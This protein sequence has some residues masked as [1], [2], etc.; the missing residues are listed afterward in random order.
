MLI[1]P[2]KPLKSATQYLVVVTRQVTSTDGVP[3]E[4]ADLFRVVRSETPVSQQT[5]PALSEL[6]DTQRA[7][8]EGIRQQFAPIFNGLAAKGIT[9]DNIVI[10][11]PFTTQ[12]ATATLKA[13]GQ[14]AIPHQLT[15]VKGRKGGGEGKGWSVRLSVGG[16]REIK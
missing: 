1:E 9:R 6:N 16:R 10:A 2:L 7:T 14:Q 11:W 13:L 12:N 15:V 8:L 4:A 3:V 5:E